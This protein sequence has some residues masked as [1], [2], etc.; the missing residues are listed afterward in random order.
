MNPKRKKN[1]GSDYFYNFV[2]FFGI[3]KFEI[4]QITMLEFK[5]S[6]VYT[7][8]LIEFQTKNIAFVNCPKFKFFNFD[9]LILIELGAKKKF[10]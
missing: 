3:S 4:S 1:N 7:I 6:E 2:I 10:L 9:I 5:I 8:Y